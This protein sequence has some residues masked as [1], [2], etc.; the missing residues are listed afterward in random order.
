MYKD[1]VDRLKRELKAKDQIIEKLRNS[2]AY[3]TTTKMGSTFSS[4]NQ[5]KL[6][7]FRLNKNYNKI[8]EKEDRFKDFEGL[9]TSS[10]KM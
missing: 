5:G 3:T 8:E 9:D 7:G 10:K 2:D 6:R 4:N 1:K